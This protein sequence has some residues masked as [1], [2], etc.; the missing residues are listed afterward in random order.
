MLKREEAEAILFEM[1][2]KKDPDIRKV[3]IDNLPER[4]R[5][6]AQKLGIRQQH[7]HY[8]LGSLDQ[9]TTGLDLTQLS[10]SER[11]QVFD[12]ISP[13]LG[14]FLEKG[15]QLHTSLPFQAGY[16]QQAFR[17]QDPVLL[18]P[19]RMQWLY[20]LLYLFHQYD[21]DLV[22]YA[23]WAAYLTGSERSLGI[24]F[25]AAIDIVGSEDGEAVFKILL[26]SGRGEHEIGSMGG[27][28]VQGLLTASRP[29]GWQFIENMLVAAQRQEGLRQVILEAAHVCHPQVF[30]RLV[31]VIREQ[32]LT[33]FSATIRAVNVWLGMQWDVDQRKQVEQTLAQ[34][35]QFLQDPQRTNQGLDSSDPEEVY[36]A[37][38]TIA[39]REVLEA[40]DPAI[41]LL[42]DPDVKQ[43]FVGAYFL[44]QTQIS[45][46]EEAVITALKD[47]DLRIVNQGLSVVIQ[48]AHSQ[49]MNHQWQETQATI[50]ALTGSELSFLGITQDR[51]PDRKDLVPDSPSS[52]QETDPLPNDIFEQLE[53]LLPRIP[54]KPI[55]LDSVVW[56]WLNY[57]LSQSQVADLLPNLLEDRSPQRLIPYLMKMSSWQKGRV[58]ELLAKQDPWEVTTREALLTLL[59]DL[60]F[61]VR[62]KVIEIFGS[63]SEP[64]EQTESIYLEGLL[65][66]KVGDLR[67]GILSLLLKQSDPFVLASSQR[68]LNQSDT[69]QRQAGLELLEQ[70]LKEKRSLAICQ[71]QAKAYQIKRKK[72]SEREES[73]LKS[74]LEVELAEEVLTLKNGLG[75]FDPA[76]KTHPIP[77]RKLDPFLVSD[78]SKKF[79][80][81]LDDWLEAHKT[82]SYF[83]PSENERQEE[84]I[85]NSFPAPSPWI[86]LEKDLENLPYLDL[87]QQWWQERPPQTQDPDG[88]E[89]LRALASLLATQWDWESCQDWEKTLLSSLATPIR[90]LKYEWPIHSLI[91]WF[92]R[93]YP[94]PIAP[95]FLLDT[96]E[97][98]L[99]LI[100]T[101]RW[102][103]LTNVKSTFNPLFSFQELNHLVDW[104]HESSPI[105]IW[106][107]V[108]REHRRLVPQVWTDPHHA[109]FWQ[110]W[111]WLDE[112]IISAPRYHPELAEIA[113]AYQAG[114]A[115][116]ADLYDHIF[117]DPEAATWF[118]FNALQELTHRKLSPLMEAY[119]F[120]VD[121]G[122]RCRD[123]I[124]SIECKRG[125]LPTVASQVALALRSVIGIQ[126][127][128]DL[129]KALG[130]EKFIRGWSYDNLSKASVLSQLIRRSFPATE[131]TPE[132]FQEQATGIPRQRLIELAMYAP[133]W[134]RYVE[135]AI[136]F[137]GFAQAV[138]WIHAHTKDTNWT[139]DAQIREGWDAQVSEYTPLSGQDLLEGAVD[140]AWFSEIHGSLTPEQ[141]SEL[142]HAA[143]Y[144]SGGTGHKRAQL[145]AEAMLG[146]LTQ[147][148][149]LTRI[150][151]KRHQ[152]SVRAL[153][154]LPLPE[155]SNRDSI[156][157]Q[158][159]EALQDFI[160]TSKQFG[161][162]RQA[163][164][165]L[166]ARIGLENLSRTAGYKDPQRL[167]WAMEAQA[168]ADL[169]QGSLSVIQQDITVSLSLEKGSPK[170]T[171]QKNGK[172]Q[173]AIP[174]SLKKDPQILALQDRKQ[175]I[176]QQAKR[177]TGSLEQAMC[178]GDLFTGSELQYLLTHPLLRPVLET[179]LFLSESK[180]ILGYP[181]ET[182]FLRYDQTVHPWDPNE[183]IRLVHPV[184][185]AISG[186]W[187]QWQQDC[188]DHKRT[189]PF[190]QIFR[191]LYLP[192]SEEQQDFG[193]QRYHGHQV[194]PKQA[195][196]LL[197]QRGWITYGEDGI[198]KTFHD[199]HISVNLEVSEG[200]GT[201]AEVEGLTLKGVYFSQ[202]YSYTPLA[203]T[204]VPARVFSEAMRDLDLLV[205]VAHRGGVDPEASAST[206]EMRKTL[207][208]ETIRLLKLNSV[209]IQG[210]HVLIKGSFGDYSLHLGSAVVHRQPGGALC[211]I[212]IQSQ[213]RGR[214]FLPF[215][216]SDPKTAEVISKMILLARDQEIKD[217]T[218]LAQLR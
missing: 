204:D 170:L 131:E 59:G 218:I 215:A 24:L 62:E 168:I 99:A 172:P 184:D 18:A 134:A 113:A 124:L 127:V 89:I 32:D 148:E 39:F 61:S 37:L 33:R 121:Y 54:E 177:M 87:W 214:L 75:L 165:K 72:L 142:D 151:E 11:I 40:L 196:A 135:A 208:Q 194:N 213:H 146:H 181:R 27:H 45:T 102:Q 210:S 125:D 2:T 41:K 115:T 147:E 110:L 21:Q 192:V 167:E 8:I 46:A 74:V 93:I 88:H 3:A 203:L 76:E 141:W 130:K 55:S 174:A 157:L 14:I 164:E 12:A 190:K 15:W 95:D 20:S 187:H 9:Q 35:D 82:L 78:S 80:T 155:G 158:R 16:I 68:L 185:L 145:F 122:N 156:L 96:F 56:P 162:Q 86:P 152:D 67:R 144:A 161:S 202:R 1:R 120:L 114:A 60:D 6:I 159:Y 57:T 178:R 119:P 189:Q 94:S 70:M 92:F 85:C 22:W 128:V 180:R 188:F 38:W 216:D 153:G 175:A 191:E 118:C 91:S 65:K 201:S 197:A 44:N 198:H 51:I 103:M 97:T 211:I 83:I 108:L 81:S 28:V 149:V 26:A 13:Q 217:P 104:R 173:K 133:Q 98:T 34:L 117:R 163:S 126:F 29:E 25:A 171:I 53:A 154:L 205:S 169:A 206:V 111:R 90:S 19:I 66:R 140:V 101:D 77:P 50:A 166:A 30:Q 69:L 186:D 52:L 200:W 179:L 17:T 195:K 183:R 63:R 79:L 73:I 112:P 64:L 84:L 129:I 116:S 123:R 105:L 100:P 209:T 42:Q 193:S 138:W 31:H 136:Q 4:L 71:E 48:K 199:D 160:R 132:D 139:V 49:Q 176:T 207:V 109:R 137:P 212:P 10:A 143:K 58:A 23:T 5:S 43:R 47:P 107:E 36:R 106:L 7:S 182:G 150:Q